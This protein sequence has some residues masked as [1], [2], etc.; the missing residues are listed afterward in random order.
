MAKNAKT[1]KILVLVPFRDRFQPIPKGQNYPPL[2][3][4]GTILDYTC[5]DERLDMLVKRGFVKVVDEKQK[6]E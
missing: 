5:D 2:I 3:E 1:T 6:S 4:K